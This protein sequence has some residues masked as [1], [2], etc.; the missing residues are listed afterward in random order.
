M[1][2]QGDRAGAPQRIGSPALFSSAA[3]KS[4]A[5]HAGAASPS[6]SATPVADGDAA[7]GLHRMRASLLDSL[8]EERSKLERERALLGR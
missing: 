2:F 7:G 3:L 1:S 6:L 5:G 4:A 8:R